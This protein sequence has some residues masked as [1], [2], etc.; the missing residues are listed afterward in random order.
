MSRAARGAYGR[1]MSRSEPPLRILVVD[2]SVVVAARVAD[3]LG[4]APGLEVVGIAHDGADALA[5]RERLRPDALVLDLAMPGLDGFAVLARVRAADP[6][7]V[8][9][10]L[11]AFD[12]PSIRARCL[13]DGA[14]GF[15]AKTE[16]LDGLPELLRAAARRRRCAE[17]EGR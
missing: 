1:A 5:R 11:S 6:G 15:V 16:P 8:V 3:L 17:G 7:C 9:V 2:D 12:E 10:I 13:A 4:E 14:D